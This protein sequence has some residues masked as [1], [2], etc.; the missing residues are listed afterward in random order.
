MIEIMN[1]PATALPFRLFHHLDLGR[2]V[3]TIEVSGPEPMK[4]GERPCVVGWQGFDSTDL[5]IAANL[6]NAKYL[7]HAANA[8][9]KLVE[10][11]AA[12]LRAPSVGSGAPGSLT[13]EVQSFNREAARA[14][15]RQIGEAA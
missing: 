13:I 15:L 2:G 4:L 8:Y 10:Q 14:L 9:P 11:L 3:G 12:F 5:D 1:R 7:V 6:K